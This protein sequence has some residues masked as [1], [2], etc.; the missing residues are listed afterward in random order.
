VLAAALMASAAPEAGN[1]KRWTT[2][3]AAGGVAAKVTTT[4]KPKIDVVGHQ[5]LRIAD[6]PMQAKL[7]AKAALLMKENERM[8]ERLDAAEAA[9]E[10]QVSKSAKERASLEASFHTKTVETEAELYRADKDSSKLRTELAR[11]QQVANQTRTWNAKLQND[12]DAANKDYAKLNESI[13][14]ASAKYMEEL[15]AAAKVYQDKEESLRQQLEQGQV[16]LSEHEAKAEHSTQEASA[17]AEEVANLKQQLST[18]SSQITNLVEAFQK[19]QKQYEDLAAQYADPSLQHFLSA[20]ATKVYQHPGIEGAANK[21]F[22]YVLPSLRTGQLRGREWINSTYTSVQGQLKSSSL[23]A[24]LGEERAKIWLPAV[25]GFVVYGLVL[26][27]LFITTWC[28]TSVHHFVCRIRPCLLFSHLYFAVVT[29]I[30]AGFAGYTGMDPLHVFAQQDKP[31]YMFVQTAFGVLL[32]FYFMV[33]CCAWCKA[34]ETLEC[35][36]RL[37]QG[38]GAGATTFAY[39]LLVWTPAMTDGMPLVESAASQA[40]VD[41][42]GVDHPPP[43]SPLLAAIPYAVPCFVFLVLLRIEQATR[44]AA[45]RAVVD[46]ED[47]ADI[48]LSMTGELKGSEVLASLIGAQEAEEDRKAE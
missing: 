37:V 9:L 24:Y 2:T 38:L 20:K 18:K 43:P 34:E 3:H 40:V 1:S 5:S 47:S 39:Y 13:A 8:K 15:E 17:R 42:L 48:T 30:A 11:A 21:T 16:K 32:G 4:R 25:S 44:R 14:L 35:S 19:M 33:I 36:C 45:K 6:D 10:A 41:A 23:Y 31:V 27:P 12:L 29:G 22:T 28:L 46:A 7:A 26:L